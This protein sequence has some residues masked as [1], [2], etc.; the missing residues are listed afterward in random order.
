MCTT[1]SS[2]E[3]LWRSPIEL[4]IKIQATCKWGVLWARAMLRKLNLT[5]IG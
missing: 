3:Y 2:E 4:K 1:E 5:E